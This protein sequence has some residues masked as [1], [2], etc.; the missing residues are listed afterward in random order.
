MAAKDGYVYL[1]VRTKK[2]EARL[3]VQRYFKNA[4]AVEARLH[5]T[6][7]DS[8]FTMSKRHRYRSWFQDHIKIG[9]SKDPTQ[10]LNDVTKNIFGSG[11]TE[12]F[13]MSDLEILNCRLLLWWYYWRPVIN[14]IL[15]IIVLIL[16]TIVNIIYTCGW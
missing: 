11:R 5:K 7:K 4:R 15:L 6:Y 14:A 10:R 16:F 3:I 12:W 13:A 9:I 1:M 8:R 2:N